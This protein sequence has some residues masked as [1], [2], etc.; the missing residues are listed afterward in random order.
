MALSLQSRK[1][2]KSTGSLRWHKKQRSM[3]IK[4]LY[5]GELLFFSLKY[6]NLREE[7]AREIK[8][9]NIFDWS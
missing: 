2:K 8:D 7:I 9:E 4:P 3:N 5:M 1:G 6:L